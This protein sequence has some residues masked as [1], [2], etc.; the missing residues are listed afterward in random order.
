ME[1][2]FTYQVLENVYSRTPGLPLDK[3]KTVL[4]TAWSALSST[5]AVRGV[6]FAYDEAQNLADHSGKE[7]FPLSLLLDTFQS[8]QRKGLPLMLVLTGLPTLFP[9][10]VEARTFSERMFRVVF[11]QS[12]PDKDSRE[13]I[14]RPIHNTQGAVKLSDRS[15]NKIISMSGGYPR[16]SSGSFAGKYTMHSSNAWTREKRRRCRLARSIR[17]WIRT[18]SPED[19]R[20]RRIDSVS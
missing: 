19:G 12:L 20:V 14:L 18:S 13:A 4:E 2:T 15:V 3:I 1:R 17:S 8:L 6:I 11:L 9:K 16:T 10:L 5:G 7:Q